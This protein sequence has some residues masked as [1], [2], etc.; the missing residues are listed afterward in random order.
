MKRLIVF[1]VALFLGST[2]FA[3]SVGA[4]RANVCPDGEGWTKIDSDDLSSYPVKGATAYCFKAGS[5]NSQGCE[6][7]LFREWPQGDDACGLSHWSYFIPEQSP[8]PTPTEEPTPTPTATPTSEPTPTPTE[9][10]TTTPT[11]SPTPTPSSTPGPKGPPE[12]EDPCFY[13]QGH[14]EC[15]P[16]EEV[17]PDEGDNFGPQK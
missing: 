14:K 16:K 4:S 13:L 7:G 2:V 10:P 5:E 11:E 3:I 9:S 6:G 15:L 12:W 1:L 17:F 8:S